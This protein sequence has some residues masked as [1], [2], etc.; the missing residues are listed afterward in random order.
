MPGPGLVGGN[1]ARDPAWELYNPNPRRPSSRSCRP[2]GNGSAYGNGCLIAGVRAARATQRKALD[3]VENFS[4]GQL[5][6][7][8]VSAA[9]PPRVLPL[10]VMDLELLGRSG[11]YGN[12]WPSAYQPSGT[13]SGIGPSFSST[14]ETQTQ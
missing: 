3:G 4:S 7:N 6:G 13:R 10:A 1:R 8:R 12:G 5:V 2:S 9:L 11:D 14:G